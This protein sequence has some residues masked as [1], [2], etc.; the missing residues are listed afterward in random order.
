MKISELYG[1]T[2]ESTAGKRGYVLSVKA[3]GNRLECLIC[4]DEEENEFTVDINS[5]LKFGNIIVFEDRESAIKSSKPLRLGRASFDESGNYLGNLDEYLFNGKT[6]LKAKIGKK[7]YP[8]AELVCG[9]AV[10]VKKIKRLKGDVV[11][12]GKVIIKSGTCL[13]DEVLS[14]ALNQGEYVQTKMKSIQ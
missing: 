10:I 9:D 7:N 12:D 6:L 13:T 5:V 8:A 11:K 14:D 1:K 2:V 3:S 4:A